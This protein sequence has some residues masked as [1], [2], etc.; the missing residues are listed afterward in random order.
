M[1]RPSTPTPNHLQS[2]NLS[3]F[4]QGA[5][6]IYVPILFH[7]LPASECNREGIIERCDKLQKSL[8][9]TLTNFYPLA[10]RF[11]ED[12]LSIH[13]NDEGVEYVESKVNAD[14]A[15][16]L[17]QGPKNIELLD[18]LLPKMDQPSSPLLGVQVNIFN[19]GGLVIAI[20]ISH[21]VADAFTLATFLNEWAQTSLTGTT[22]KGCFPSFSHLSSLFPARVLSGPQFS[23]P[24]NIGPKIVTRRFVF[25]AL[26]IVKLKDIIN[27]SAIFTRPTRVVV[28]MSL[29]WKVLVGISS[30][31]LGYSRDSCFLFPINLRGKSNL[32]SLEHALG[33]FYVTVVAT[34]EANQLRN[35]LNDFVSAIGCTARD[36]SVSIGKASID[37]IISLAINC[38]TEV[39]NKLGQGDEMDIYASTSW[40]RFPWYEVDFGWGKPIW[41]S[42]VGRTFEVISLFDTKNGDGIEAWVSLKEN[43]MAEFERDPNILS[44]TSKVASMWIK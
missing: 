18:D 24:S 6:R 40:C 15:E 26:A 13:C 37:D 38:G 42:S 44:S 39:V 25:D 7:Y 29:I 2:L 22:T 34:L 23:P 5:P 12:E 8:A 3:F 17:H 20:Q 4:D 9:E 36:T 43:D 28:V 31:K 27:S 35:E 14:L 21:I 32:P 1:I 41:V 16:F 19:C 30:A 11:S 10:G 33:N